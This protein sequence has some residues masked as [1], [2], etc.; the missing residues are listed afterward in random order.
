MCA[1]ALKKVTT[2]VAHGCE[3]IRPANLLYHLPVVFYF[4]YFFT[5]G[6]A[7][8]AYRRH[9]SSAQMTQNT[10]IWLLNESSVSVFLTFNMFTAKR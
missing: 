6:H 8:L 9:T 5:D 10:S 4:P 2:I 3:N 7:A 1:C